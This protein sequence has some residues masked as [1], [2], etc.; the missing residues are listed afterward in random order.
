MVTKREH[1]NRPYAQ[2]LVLTN[3]TTGRRVGISAMWLTTFEEADSG[4]VFKFTNG[5]TVT[6]EEN[7]R[8]VTTAFE[9][10]CRS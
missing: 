1:E 8:E 4:T 5:E 6:V 7:F 9:R 2:V 3:A 10:T